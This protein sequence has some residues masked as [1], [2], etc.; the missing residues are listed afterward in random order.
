MLMDVL[1]DVA[2]QPDV[3]RQSKSILLLGPPGVG[4]A[5]C[6]MCCNLLC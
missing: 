2:S 5:L 1:V 3:S 6:P 4:M